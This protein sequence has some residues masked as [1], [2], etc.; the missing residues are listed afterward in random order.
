MIQFTFDLY[1]KDGKLGRRVPFGYKFRGVIMKW[2]LESNPELGDAFHSP[3]EVRPYAI[4]TIPHKKEGKI[5]FILTSYN[6]ELSDTVIHDLLQSEKVNLTVDRQNFFI[7][8]IT[9]ERPNL[10]QMKE[11]ARPLKKLQIQF[12]TPLYLNTSLGDYPVRF[13]LPNPFFGNLANLWNDINEEALQIDRDAFLEWIDAHV[14]I[15]GYKMRS[16]K[17]DIG[18]RKPV[19]GGMGNATYRVTKINRN[20]YKC[21]LKEANR[22]YDVQFV[23]E[24]FSN[25]CQWLDILCKLGT[26]TNVGGNRTAGM[27]VI[28]YFPKET[29]TKKDL[30]KNHNK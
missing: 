22:K 11:H 25:N 30:L 3:G 9:F 4:N 27:G 29:L 10:V 20:Y 8:R 12:V 23:N 18:K 1:P 2:L 15:S 17:R 14:Y 24:H 7:A 28:R 13:P 26:Y 19:V 21:L 16:A 6:E 5:E